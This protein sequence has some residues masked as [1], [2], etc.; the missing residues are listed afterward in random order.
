MN[1][2]RRWLGYDTFKLIVALLILLFLIFRLLQPAPAAAL[3][4]YPPA[5]FT[6]T[7]S[8]ATRQLSDPQGVVIFGLDEA[9]ARWVPLV[10]NEIGAALPQEGYRLEQGASGEWQILS[11]SG[12]VLYTL[13]APQYRWVKSSL[14][15][16][17]VPT[18]T[19]TPLPP[20]PTATPT[21]AAVGYPTATEVPAPTATPL[22]PPTPTPEAQPTPTPTPEAQPT[23]TPQAAAVEVPAACAAAAVPRLAVGSQAVVLSNL[24]FRS[25]P[26][27][28]ANLVRT[29]RAGTRLTVLEGPVCT[30]Y[31]NGA[32]LWWK[33]RDPA[34]EE[35]WSAE[36]TLNGQIYLMGPAQ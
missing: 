15:Q 23:P 9:N 18:A 7:W 4:P 8:D 30:P 11:M 32:Y 24:N 31:R 36:A 14:A 26:E 16:A 22:T 2:Q 19:A 21:K 1:T 13:A 25:S 33:V 29:N 10:P 27:I 20:S 28:G 3:P 5:N 12:E 34:G 6:W 35:G 17:A